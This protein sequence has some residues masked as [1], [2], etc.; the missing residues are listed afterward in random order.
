MY[1]DFHL[2]P[3]FKSFLRKYEETYPANR[4]LNELES[5]YDPKHVLLDLL[6]ELFLHILDSQSSLE[7]LKS[8][9]GFVGIASIVPIEYAFVAASGKFAGIMKNPS[10]MAPADVKHLSVVKEGEVSYCRQFIRELELYEQMHKAG[11]IFL[12]SRKFNTNLP[13]DNIPSF[14]LSIEGGHTLLRHK[15]GKPGTADFIPVN[16]KVEVS[17]MVHDFNADPP[18]DAADSLRRIFNSMWK[19]NLDLLYLTLT[20]LTNIPTQLLANH[21][22]GFKMLSHADAFPQAF[23]ITEAGK[24]VIDAAY[25][26]KSPDDGAATP[27]LIDIK[28]MSLKSRLDLYNY[29][30]EKQYNHPILATHMGVTGYALNEWKE[31]LR[32]AAFYRDGSEGSPTVVRVL[33]KRKKA[34][35]TNDLF[36]GGLEYNAWS[37]NMMDEDII[38]VLNSEGLIGVSLDMRILGC[39]YGINKFTGVFKNDEKEFG[40]FMSQEEFKYFFP[41]RFAKM[42]RKKT[43]SFAVM[44]QQEGFITPDMEERHGQTLCLNIL[45]IVSVGFMNKT[46]KNPWKAICIGSDFDGLIDPVKN[47]RNAAEFPALERDLRRWMIRAEREYIEYNGGPEL[48]PRDAKGK[49]DE[50]K[51]DQLLRDFCYNNGK[52]FIVN[53]IT[54]QD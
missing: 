12:L 54:G 9:R 51:L 17:A 18:L 29:R 21:A 2:H 47:C 52:A 7:Q 40:E 24:R 32:E 42:T 34:G 19:S 22:F 48:L 16:G 8:H 10:V 30:R 38:E 44:K 1:F 6:D 45:H 36:L 27:V 33:T 26:M 49:V 39:Q 13:S 23:G 5:S 3:L 53:W 41:E 25:T 15:T 46:K 4:D 20:H 50:Q 43:E 37:I 11:K 31:A 35:R 28:H 14:A